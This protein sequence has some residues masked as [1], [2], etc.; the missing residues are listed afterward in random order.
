MMIEMETGIENEIEITLIM[1]MRI[2]GKQNV[3]NTTTKRKIY[4][5]KK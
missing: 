4:R 3:P 2:N 1:E 5:N